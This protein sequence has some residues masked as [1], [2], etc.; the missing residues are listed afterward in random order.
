MDLADDRNLGSHARRGL[1]DRRQVVEVQDIGLTRTGQHELSRP[2]TYLELV[3]PIVNHGEH[4]VRGTRPVLIGRMEG[5]CSR[6]TIES[7]RGRAAQRGVEAHRAHL[8]IEAPGVPVRALVAA[9]TG[10]EGHGAARTPQTAC[11]RTRGR[12]R[13]T[14]G[15]EQDR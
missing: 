7:Q 4:R 3:I 10:D 11:Q 15:R 9:R 12:R 6:G 13:S 5:S 1:I 8:S 2:G 14:A